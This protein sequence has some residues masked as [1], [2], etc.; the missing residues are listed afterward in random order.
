MVPNLISSR[1]LKE[2][3]QWSRL[4]K[5]VILSSYQ[6]LR[7]LPRQTL[8]IKILKLHRSTILYQVSISL[9]EIYYTT[10]YLEKRCLKDL[11][12]ILS[13]KY[14][15]DLM[16]VSLLIEMIDKQLKFYNG[17]VI[18]WSWVSLKIFE[19]NYIYFLRI[20]FLD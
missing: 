5:V 15:H 20:K 10:Q 1:L 14:Q 4:L 3:Q 2:L 13:D 8:I 19:I 16:F 17:V 18:F 11:I 7:W 6:L 9:N 12:F